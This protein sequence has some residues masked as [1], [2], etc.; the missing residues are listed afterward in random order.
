M[1]FAE[2]LSFGREGEVIVR[3]LLESSGNLE[4]VID[5]SNDKYFQEKDID[6][7]GIATDGHIAKYEVKTD[8]M[9]HETGNI[10]FEIKTSGN[11]GCLAKTEA[12]YIMYYIEGNGKLYCFNAEQ[13]RRYLERHRFK[14]YRMG[15]NAEGY[16]LNI[17]QLL[18][19]GQMK[20]IRTYE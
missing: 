14:L 1:S 19:D 20:R 18:R 10:A 11:I 6:L 5:C 17:N 9:A 16:L 15:D 4:Q 8:R 3:N 13:M 7:L 12:D 2:D